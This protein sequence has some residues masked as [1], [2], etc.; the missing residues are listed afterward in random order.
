MANLSKRINKLNQ[1]NLRNKVDILVDVT[2][3]WGIEETW[4]KNK[5][6]NSLQPRLDYLHDWKLKIGEEVYKSRENFNYV[7]VDEFS[8]LDTFNSRLFDNSCSTIFTAEMY[9]ELEEK[10]FQFQIERI[11]DRILTNDNIESSTFKLK[12][13]VSEW[14]LYVN[15][16]LVRIF[17]EILQP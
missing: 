12:N 9:L 1:I 6:H 2:D 16:T 3:L 7:L 4:K 5:I 10:Y 11:T 8:K 14:E 13:L 15:Q 17:K